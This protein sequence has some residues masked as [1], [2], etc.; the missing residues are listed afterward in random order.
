MKAPR[1]KGAADRPTAK[2]KSKASGASAASG[3]RFD[4]ALHPRDAHGHWIT[5]G[6]GIRRIKEGTPARR[7]ALARQ[8]RAARKKAGGDKAARRKLAARARVMRA[9][10]RAGPSPASKPTATRRVV[11]RPAVATPPAAPR[12][13]GESLTKARRAFADDRERE[14]ARG[15]G[16]KRLDDYQ[17]HDVLVPK[18]GGK[19]DHAIEVKSLI[20]GKKRQLAV[21][22]NALLRKVEDAAAHPGRT[23]HTV[24]VDGRNVAEGGVHAANY[25]GHTLYY[26]RASGPYTVT[27]MYKVKNMAELKKLLD[28]PDERL[29]AAARGSFPAGHALKELKARAAKE[30]AYNDARSKERKARLGA[31]AYGR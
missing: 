11:T 15:I 20:F 10:R 26:R 18:P 1:A 31:S 4:P 23:Y 3:A 13:T 25:S 27:T 9:A 24:V 30:K 29:P 12:V 8:I 17:P 2:A 22:E 16:G 7:S 5:T 28:T 21:H 19:G 14:I 6:G